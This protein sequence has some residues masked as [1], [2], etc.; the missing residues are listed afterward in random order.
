MHQ[1]RDPKV[2][3]VLTLN[4]FAMHFSPKEI[5]DVLCRFQDKFSRISVILEFKMTDMVT[6]PPFSLVKFHYFYQSLV[7]SVISLFVDEGQAALG[8]WTGIE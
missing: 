6:S 5:F 1:D 2:S 3:I 7:N 8:R 4:I